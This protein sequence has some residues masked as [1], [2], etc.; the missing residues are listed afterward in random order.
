MPRF[1][2]QMTT[3]NVTE[4]SNLSMYITKAFEIRKKTLTL[5]KYCPSRFHVYR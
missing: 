4:I 5:I 2:E 1:I 3:E